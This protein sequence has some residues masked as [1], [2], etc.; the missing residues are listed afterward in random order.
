MQ[1]LLPSGIGLLSNFENLPIEVLTVLLTVRG[2]F[3]DNG[4][5]V[6]FRTEGDIIAK[7]LPDTGDHLLTAPTNKFVGFQVG[8]PQGY[9][10]AIASRHSEEHGYAGDH[11]PWNL[12]PQEMHSSH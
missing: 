5:A 3:P 2:H 10:G 9:H 7:Y 12:S 8:S 4:R 1:A 6:I 11:F